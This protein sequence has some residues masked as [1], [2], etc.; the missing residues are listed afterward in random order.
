[1][2]T[3]GDNVLNF[4][5]FT[6]R[7]SSFSEVSPVVCHCLFNHS[8]SGIHDGDVE[9]IGQIDLFSGGIHGAAGGCVGLRCRGQA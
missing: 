2:N 3:S 5:Y 1:V 8:V 4:P 9:L 6:V 7:T